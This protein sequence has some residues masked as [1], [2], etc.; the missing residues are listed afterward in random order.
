[1]SFPPEHESIAEH[2][3]FLWQVEDLMRACDLNI[4]MVD[5]AVIQ[6]LPEEAD[7]RNDARKWYEGIIDSIKKEKLEEG[8]H[9][10]MSRELV[11]E[12]TYLHHTLLTILNDAKYKEIYESALPAIRQFQSIAAKEIN[13]VE[14]CLTGMYSKLLLRLQKKEIGQKTE[15][16]SEAFRNVLAYLSARYKDM[17]SGKL[18]HNLN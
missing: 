1:M 15:E 6:T 7:M 4:D 8:G 5:E 17:K 9:L 18:P 2:I 12:L 16:A 10:A 3:L 14:T 13:E 11:V